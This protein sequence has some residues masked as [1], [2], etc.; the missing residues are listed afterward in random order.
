MKTKQVPRTLERKTEREIEAMSAASAMQID[1]EEEERELERHR[2]LHLFWTKRCS[3]FVSLTLAFIASGWA[4]HHPE[5]EVSKNAFVLQNH[6][7]GSLLCLAF[8]RRVGTSRDTLLVCVTWVAQ[9]TRKSIAAYIPMSSAAASTPDSSEK[10]V[11]SCIAPHASTGILFDASLLA[12][13]H[14]L[15]APVVADFATSPQSAAD[16]L[17]TELEAAPTDD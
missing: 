4:V 11:C 9:G 8:D 7:T 2:Q 17:R 5:T 10:A 1:K 12:T 6:V 13:V 16:K 14:N 3:R 15:T